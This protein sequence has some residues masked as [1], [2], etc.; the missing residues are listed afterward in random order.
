MR[1]A[2][3]FMMH[4]EASF[5]ALRIAANPNAPELGEGILKRDFNRQ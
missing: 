5:G 4:L 3:I 2:I 1:R